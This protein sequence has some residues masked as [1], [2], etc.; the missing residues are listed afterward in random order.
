MELLVESPLLD[1]LLAARGETDRGAPLLA[2][3]GAG[4]AEAGRRRSAACATA[5]L[6]WAAR[7]AA[8]RRPSVA[9]IDE[10]PRPAGARS[11]GDDAPL[12]LATAH[13]TKGLEWDHVAVI[14]LEVGRFPEPRA[15]SSPPPSPSGRSRRSA[16]SRYVAWTRARRSLTLLY[17]P[18]APSPF[19]LEAFS[20]E[21]LGVEPEAADDAAMTADNAAMTADDARPEP[22]LRGRLTFL[23]PLERSDIPTVVRWFNDQATVRFLSARAPIGIAQEE[24]WFERMLEDHG[25]SAWLFA[26]CRLDDE[27]PIGTIGLFLVDLTNGNAGVGISIG[28]PAEAGR[29]F[30]SDAMEV[31]LDFGFGRLRLERLWLDAYDFNERAIRVVRAARLRARGG[32]AAWRVPRRAL[33]RR[34]GDGHAAGGVGRAA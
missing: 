21:E 5:L 23:R 3:R 8:T 29:G 12:T 20:A 33:R 4:A 11:G 9:A 30:G 31:L 28:D 27:R 13:G 34:R 15:P 32:G 24:R 10:R 2:A 17:D 26:I 7:F 18:T 14:G 22:V 19:L 25:K 6:A 1:P 16:G